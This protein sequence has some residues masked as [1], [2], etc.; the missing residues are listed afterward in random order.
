[1][2]HI[3]SEELR[4]TIAVVDHP[5]RKETAAYRASRTL[6]HQIIDTV[7]DWVLGPGPYEDHHGGAL[8]VKDGAGWL[9]IQLP[10]GIEWSAQ[11]CA[12]PEKIDALRRHT[13]RLLTAFPDT[14]ASYEGLGYARGQELLDTPITDPAGVEA[15]TDSIFNASMPIPA[16][17][18]RG[19]LPNGAGYHHYPKPIVD[20]NHFKRDDFQLFVQD[21][22]GLP[23]VV[24]PVSAAPDDRRVR[25][26]AAHPDSAYAT[27]LF[28]DRRRPAEE[29]A[30]QP[31]EEP[32][33][34]AGQLTLREQDIDAD[35]D[36]DARVL[37][38][39]D[40]LSLQAFRRFTG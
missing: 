32:A 40:P 34:R 17:A 26:L 25:L 35:D 14:V 27:R 22:A 12:D 39:A 10:L 31:L 5:K 37:S 23:A 13:Q 6:M 28:H 1:M 16:A 19:Y 36:A 20:I 18:H 2:T 24:V 33:P 38:A 15:W 4:W 9:F 21:D 11:F 8:W 7:P 29:G 3:E 30:R